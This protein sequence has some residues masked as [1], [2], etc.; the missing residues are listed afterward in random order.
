[1]EVDRIHAGRPRRPSELVCHVRAA[2]TAATKTNAPERRAAA[3]GRG[4][5]RAI[6]PA[7]EHPG[8]RI[9]AGASG[10]E[11]AIVSL[12][13]PRKLREWR[14]RTLGAICVRYCVQSFGRSEATR[15]T[16]KA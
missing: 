6:P 14:N 11:E 7:G 2:G 9:L 15:G 8:D 13:I 3:P 12:P 4:M 10:V 16:V 5:T 1:L